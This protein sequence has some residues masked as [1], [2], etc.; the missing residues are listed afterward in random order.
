MLGFVPLAGNALQ[1]IIARRVFIQS[2]HVRSIV[3]KVASNPPTHD[4]KFLCTDVQ[5]MPSTF[6]LLVIFAACG[7]RRCFDI[8]RTFPRPIPRLD[9]ACEPHGQPFCMWRCGRVGLEFGIDPDAVPTIDG[10]GNKRE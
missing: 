9:V 3:D 2:K 4:R 6:S 8:S 10:T 1:N 5:L 7:I